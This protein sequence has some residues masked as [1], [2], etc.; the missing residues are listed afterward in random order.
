[1]SETL[2]VLSLDMNELLWGKI[3]PD[4]LPQAVKEEK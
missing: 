4:Y 3:V 1:L 2:P